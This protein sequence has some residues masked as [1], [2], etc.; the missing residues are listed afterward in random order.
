METLKVNLGD[1]ISIQMLVTTGGIGVGELTPYLR[2]EKVSNGQLYDFSTGNFS[3]TPV[4]PFAALTEDENLL[5]VYYYDFDT[6]VLST[7][8]DL[9]V[10]M[11]NGS[12]AVTE[13]RL[14]QV[15]KITEPFV[16]GYAVQ[17]LSTGIITIGGFL[18]LKTGRAETP[19]RATF[20]IRNQDGTVYRV[21][22]QVTSHT[23]GIFSLAV[24]GLTPVQYKNYILNVTI[25][26]DGLSFSGSFPFIS[27]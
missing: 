8:D 15:Q 9:L 26:N 6:S 25:E 17:D 7:D 16:V 21:A 24:S 11:Y 20:E 5:G 12:P 23:S 4:T 10:Y 27:F 22:E 18:M 14:Y 3:G 19:S 1:T 13:L 2:I